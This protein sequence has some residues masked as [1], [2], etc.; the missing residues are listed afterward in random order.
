M[1]ECRLWDSGLGEQ[2]NGLMGLMGHTSSIIGDSGDERNADY[3][4]WDS[5]GL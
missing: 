4:S 5:E 2:L 1:A 3:D